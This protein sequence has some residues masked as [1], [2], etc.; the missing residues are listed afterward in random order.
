MLKKSLFCF[1]AKSKVCYTK[2]YIYTFILLDLPMGTSFE[3]MG[4]MI[5]NPKKSKEFP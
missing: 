2:I 1:R 3:K 4:K 5:D